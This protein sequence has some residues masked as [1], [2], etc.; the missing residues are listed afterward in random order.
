[1]PRNRLRPHPIDQAAD[2]AQ[3]VAC[4]LC[5]RP[6]GKRIEWHHPVPKSRGGRT[7]EPVHPIC[8]RT[9]HASLDNKALERDYATPEKL[10]SHPEIA[11]FVA[12][13]ANKDPDFHVPTRRKR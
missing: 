9:I 12:W 5:E 2:Q 11:R 6:L 3:P 7:T 8:H 13:V 10:R 4:F 1:V